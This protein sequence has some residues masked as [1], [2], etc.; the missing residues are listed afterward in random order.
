MIPTITTR[1]RHAGTRPLRQAGKPIPNNLWPQRRKHAW[2]VRWFAPGPDGKVVRPSRAFDTKAQAEAFR[3]EKQEE[4]NKTPQSRRVPR[5]VTL[6]EF[7]E[8]FTHLRTG[9]RG[10]RLKYSSMEDARNSLKRFALF[11]GGDKPLSQITTADAVKFVA[12]LR[13][14]RVKGDPKRQPSPATVNKAKRTL[15]AAFSVAV[16][17]LGYLRENPF[18]PIKPDRVP[19]SPIRYVTPEEF[20]SLVATC[21]RQCGGAALWWETFLTVC[22]TAGLRYSEGLNLTWHDID[23]EGD[24][25]TVVAKKERP[26]TIAWTPKDYETRT[27]PIPSET[28]A[29]LAKL[30][31]QSPD[32]YAYVFLPVQ[33]FELIKA[34]QESGRWREGQAVINNF[35]RRFEQIV[36]RSAK[37]APTLVDTER[38]PTISIHDLRRSA[39]T[40]WSKAVNMQTVMRMAGHSNIETTQ[41]YYAAATEDQ[42]AMVRRASRTA[43]RR[44]F[45]GQTDPKVTPKPVLGVAKPRRSSTKSLSNKTLRL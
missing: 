3:A 1:S 38:K 36:V 27:I 18:R 20:A 42:F 15:K 4:L 10:Q 22:Y 17:P 41:R 35:S 13:E 11:V 6:S 8:E 21:R 19:D 26:E 44:A 5:N 39:I 45:R 7:V 34:A 37:R 24:R 9:P 2:V 25:I 12:S 29:L 31:H 43:I 30:Q 33:R 32:G 23:F 14:G 28:V 16:S 40:N